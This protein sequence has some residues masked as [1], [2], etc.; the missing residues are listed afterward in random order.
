MGITILPMSALVDTRLLLV[1][2]CRVV[3]VITLSRRFA[4]RCGQS[5][6]GRNFKNFLKPPLQTDKDLIYSRCFTGVGDAHE[7]SKERYK[8]MKMTTPNAMLNSLVNAWEK[9]HTLEKAMKDAS[10]LT[11]DRE[12]WRNNRNRVARAAEALLDAYCD[13]EN[14]VDSTMR[15]VEGPN[16]EEAFAP[17]GSA[18]AAMYAYVDE[19]H[20]EAYEMESDDFLYEEKDA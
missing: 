5:M 15:P 3:G 20:S 10:C 12:E 4:M 14:V 18:Y 1:V 2:L 19:L 6:G 9:A 11:M 16:C 17:Y 13:M 7:F 8:T